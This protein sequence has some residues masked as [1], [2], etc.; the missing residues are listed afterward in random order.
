VIVEAVRLLITLALLAVGYRVGP[1]LNTQN[2]D[3]AQALGA[4]I[5][6]GVGYVLG[7]ITGR[8]F[9]SSLDSIP[10]SVVARSTGPEM[11]AGA[12]GLIVGVFVGMVIALPVIVFVPAVIGVPIA[13]LIVL[14]LAIVG[15][16]LFA[17]RADEILAAAGLRRRGD[18]VSRQ[19]DEG[20]FL[21]DSSAAIDG[22]VLN[23]ARLGLLRG[24]VW[25]PGF[26]IDELQGLADSSDQERRKRGRR[27]LE[28]IESLRDVEG[29]EVAILEESVPG[30]EEVDA[31]LIVIAAKADAT[32]ITTDRNL[33][34]ASSTRGI[35]VLNPHSLADAMQAPVAVGDQLHVTVRRAGSEPGQGVAYLDDGTMVV[36]ENAAALLDHNVD[37]EVTATTRTAVGRMLFGRLAS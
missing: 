19:L 31:K 18:L 35:E 22:R 16:R 25:V 20:A 13:V 11:F 6:T 36:V 14:M 10:K 27:G 33:A 5:G 24:R 17:G 8:L 3:A 2:P 29:T 21:V 15:A 12:F 37:I 9:R 7:G 23:L 26:V 30:V 28:V 1:M 32:L 4:I 34:L